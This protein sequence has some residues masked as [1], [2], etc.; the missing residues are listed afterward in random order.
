MGTSFDAHILIVDFSDT[1]MIQMAFD[2]ISPVEITSFDFHPEYDKI[3]VGGC[4]NGQVIIWDVS[5][6]DH[7]VGV[8]KG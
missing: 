2:L 8:G 7:K 6:Q 5:S 3:V 1:Q 4:L